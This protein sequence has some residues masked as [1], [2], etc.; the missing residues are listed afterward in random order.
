M[1]WLD[2]LWFPPVM[3]AIA[4]VLG[5]ASADDDP[6]GDLTRSIVRTF[7]MLSVS[8]VAVGVVLHLV[9]NAFAG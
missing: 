3:L 5:A 4:M 7:V 6:P 1:T 2:L 8:V 9:A